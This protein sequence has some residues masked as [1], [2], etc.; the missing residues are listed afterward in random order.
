MDQPEGGAA[1]VIS[2]EIIGNFREKRLANLTDCGRN[3]CGTQPRRDCVD[4][5]IY[6]FLSFRDNAQCLTAGKCREVKKPEGNRHQRQLLDDNR[7]QRS[8]REFFRR[9]P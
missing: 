2:G 7:R 3:L 5:Y 4:I 1:G 8:I 6:G 9:P